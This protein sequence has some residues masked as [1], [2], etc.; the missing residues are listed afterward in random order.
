MWFSKR[1]KEVLFKL[2]KKE[3]KIYV[4][5]RNAQILD[6]DKYLFVAIFVAVISIL[7]AQKQRQKSHKIR[8]FPN[9][10]VEA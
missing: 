9:C 4:S 7:I 1:L 3:N 5:S 6:T 10:E 8:I 2:E